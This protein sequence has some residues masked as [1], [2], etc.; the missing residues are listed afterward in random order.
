MMSGHHTF[1]RSGML[2]DLR[3][4]L[5]DVRGSIGVVMA[6]A[7]VA[8]IVAVGAAVDLAQVLRAREILQ[9]ALDQ[10]TIRAALTTGSGYVETGRATLAANLSDTGVAE[11]NLSSSFIRNSDGSTSGSAT[12]TVPLSFMGI[13]GKNDMSV[14][15]TAKATPKTAST[16][17]PAGSVCILLVSKN[18]Q[19]LLVNSGATVNAPNC[20]I[21][22]QSNAGSAAIFNGGTTINSK[23]ICIKSSSIIDNGGTHPNLEKGCSPA[24]DPY[25]ATLPAVTA[26]ACNYNGRNID[27]ATYTFEPGV[28]CGGVNFNSSQ[29]VATFNPGLYIIKGGD[30]NIQGTLRGTGVTFYFADTSKFQFNSGAGTYLKAPT[31][32]PYANVLIYETTANANVT[33]WPWNDSPGHELTG[34]IHLPSRQLTMN[35]GMTASL[36]KVT[37]VADSLILNQTSW[38]LAPDVTA[39]SNGSTTTTTTTSGVFL[40]H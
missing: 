16:T 7:L 1:G 20:E 36:D 33:Q 24:S 10:A 39:I 34:L 22:V 29:T 25:A 6:V 2:R 28:H 40:S 21:H 5:A 32:G 18:S 11:E 19:A 31:S 12:I 37:I 8:L 23:K 17:T 3:G 30:W 15:V 35:S 9:G 13:I 14:G 27:A 26:G 38:N 4:F